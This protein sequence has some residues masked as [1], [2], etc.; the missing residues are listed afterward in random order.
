MSGVFELTVPDPGA[1]ARHGVD[2]ISA[3]RRQLRELRSVAADT[4][5]LHVAGDAWNCGRPDVADQ[6]GAD[7]EQ[8]DLEL[9]DAV[10]D[11]VVDLI[12][13]RAPV[14]VAV[15]GTVADAGLALFACA[16]L[17]VV[18]PDSQ[19]QITRP[20][21]AL[22][23]PVHSTVTAASARGTLER[24]AWAGAAWGAQ[25]ALATGLASVLGD[26]DIARSHAR[27]LAEDPTGSAAFKRAL[28]ARRVTAIRDIARYERWLFAEAAAPEVLTN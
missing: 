3:V 21:N 8:A 17:R 11:A 12:A 2:A 5:L 27:R 1:G 10:T 25:D 7:F 4:V 20:R 14:V 28:T 22:A 19:L 6:T 15:D 16:D 13:I 24:M 26:L 18:T 23:G 9:A